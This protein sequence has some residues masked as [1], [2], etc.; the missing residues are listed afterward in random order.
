VQIVIVG[1][2]TV[3]FELAVHL[4]KAG[5]DVSLVESDAARCAE[6][7]EKLD[8]LVVDGPGSSPR[9]LEHAGLP[10]AQMVL[11]VT[12][13]DEVN[14]LVCGIAAQ[15]DVPTRI[16]RIRSSEFRGQHATVD[17]EQL[18]VTRV[19]DPEQVLVR[20]IDQIA[21]I[22]DAVEVFS[23]HEG[24]ILIA[25]HIMADGMPILDKNLIEILRMAGD[26]QFLSV[27][28]KR[29]QEE[30]TW[31]PAG[32]DVLR[33]GDDVT[34]IFPRDSLP[35]YL[36]L[37]NL[38]GKRVHK[39][40]VAGDGRTA[41]QLSEDLET[42]V[43]SVTLVSPDTAHARRAADLLD[44]AE[45]ICGDAT[46]RNVMMEVGVDS[47]DLFVG[48]GQRTTHNV[49]GALLARAEGTKRVIA[50]SLE[51]K[52]NALFRSLG[53]DHVISPRRAMAQEIIDLIHRG[54][55]SVELQ[56]RD[57]NLESV[58]LIAGENAKITRAPLQKVWMP[59][60]RQA[61]VGAVVRDGQVLIPR[62]KTQIQAGDEVI[63][64]IKPQHIHKIQS[65]FK[66]RSA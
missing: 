43:E 49:M 40:I 25:R 27:A 44:R 23:Y 16:A 61:I 17:L 33:A 30:K 11:A 4:Q 5:H 36:E 7:S 38:T 12:S 53:V 48:V 64:V 47:A 3:G 29:E 52:N 24:Q 32:D 39:A 58:E 45:V 35:K 28:L 8:I 46:E 15:F 56:L 20:V 42:W 41:I 26:D 22:P 14:I 37:L 51:P 6:I 13:V 9:V 34:T 2:G 65:L 62:G 19:I 18:G 55:R 1:A 10:D 66:G 54:R 21:R 31:I 60:K 59:Y 63:V 50:M 57:M